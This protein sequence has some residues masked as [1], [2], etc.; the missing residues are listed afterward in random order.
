MLYEALKSIANRLGI[1]SYVRLIE[2]W[3]FDTTRSVK[4][5][6]NVREFDPRNI[7]GQIRDSLT[8][9]PVRPA[10]ARAALRDLPIGNHSNYTFIDMGSGKGRMLFL[11]SELSFRKI[12]GVEFATDLHEQ[13]RANIRRCNSRR[14]KC[15]DI[16][17]INTNATEFEFPDE[18]L[19][20]CLFN[21][22]GPEVLGRMLT[23][24]IRS[25]ERHPRHIVVLLIWPK[26]SY[27]VAQTPG[28]Q[29]YKQTRRHHIY[30]TITPI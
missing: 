17:S 25:I 23:N 18:N 27:L 26:F 2:D 24:L 19:V 4:T 11:A 3:W 1:D 21:P 16:E 30:Q 10:N 6:G 22:F 29:V 15:V 14:R 13:A 28:M 7:V 8:Y 12:E 5:S 20:I 9:I